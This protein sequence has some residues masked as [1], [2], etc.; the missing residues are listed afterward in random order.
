[1][2]LPVI[3][4]ALSWV[5]YALAFAL[6]FHYLPDRR[7]GWGRALIG[8]TLTASLF[9]LGRALIGWYLERAN[10]GA[11]Y[12]AMGVLV[13]TL[14]WMYYAGL[15]VFIGALLTAVIDERATTSHSRSAHPAGRP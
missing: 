14:F 12:G 13:L 9:V 4:A 2:D 3:A 11:A 10:P 7:V 6:M 1:M 5:I 8:G 15:I